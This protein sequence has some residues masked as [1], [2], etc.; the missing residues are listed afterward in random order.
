MKKILNKFLILLSKDLVLKSEKDIMQI[1]YIRQVDMRNDL[2]EK[3]AQDNRELLD[4]VNSLEQ[5]LEDIEN[6]DNWQ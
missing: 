5:R 3:L 1:Y 6:G 2:L 4:M